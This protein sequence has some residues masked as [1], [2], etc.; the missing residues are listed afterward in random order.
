[1]KDF[2]YR[3][4]AD[5]RVFISWRGRQATTLKGGKADAF[6]R[7]IDGLDEEGRQLEMARVTGNF[8]RGN[9]PRSR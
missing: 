7:R 5:G 6:L 2:S 8:K 4:T 1:M 9:E 3:T